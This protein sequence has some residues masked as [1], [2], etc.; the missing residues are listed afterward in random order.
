MR[1]LKFHEQKLLKKTDFLSWKGEDNLRFNAILR[2]YHV[3]NADDL[4]KYQ[5]L[6]GMITSLITKLRALPPTSNFRVHATQQLLQKLYSM[7]LI[8]T[9]ATALPAEKDIK[10]AAFCRRRL[11]IVMVRLKMAQT[12][13]AAVELVQHGHV[14]VGPEVVTDAA[15]LVTR[16]FEDHVTWVDSSKIKR[17]IATYNDQ[18]DD[19]EL[20]GE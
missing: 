11:P 9:A 3:E 1:K 10:A 18:L 16:S 14:R 2:R 13:R 17:T 8:P 5:K 4:I 6:C 20:L 12:V 15:F 7:G 19:F